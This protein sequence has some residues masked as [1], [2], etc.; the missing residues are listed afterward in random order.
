LASCQAFF[1][2]N[3]DVKTD[4][5]L[6]AMVAV[7]SWQLVVFARGGQW[8]NL[9]LGFLA[10][11]LAMLSKGPIGVVAPAM[12][13]GADFVIRRDWKGLLNWRWLLGIPIFLVVQI[14]FCIG[15]YDQFGWEGV[16]FYFWTQ[17]FGRI[18]GDS[19]W[20]NDATVFFF[21]HNFAWSFLPWVGAA[22][23]AWA[24][25]G[26]RILRDGIYLPSNAEAVSWAGFFFVFCAL[27]LSRFKLPHYI[28]LTYPFAAIMTAELLN[29]WIDSPRWEKYAR[30]LTG[31]HFGIFILGWLLV[32]FLSFWAFPGMHFLW[33]LLGIA[34]GLGLV[35]LYVQFPDRLLRMI[36]IPA[37][38]FA[39]C[40]FLINVHVYPQLTDYQST[41]MAGKH[42]A[43]QQLPPSRVFVYDKSGRALDFYSGQRMKQVTDVKVAREIAQEAPIYI[44]TTVRG[45]EHFQSISGINVKTLREFEH[46]SVAKL[47]LPFINPSLRPKVLGKRFLLEVSAR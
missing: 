10:M 47:S 26:Y 12:A 34:G 40:N 39:L 6:V 23:I 11:G 38:G 18:T 2:M 46:F 24:K 35:Y 22:V 16:E 4:M 9:Q 36:V 20:T 27:S 21:V 45:L 42:I 28:F 19:E 13:L 15:L 8:W 33:M 32:F 37:A 30:I 7:A 1:L 3:H 44:Y 25:K 43:E 41:A 17:S 31:V 14:P 5:F 29:D